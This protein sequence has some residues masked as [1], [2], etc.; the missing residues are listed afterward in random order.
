MAM[1]S[2]LFALMQ[3][4]RSLLFLRQLWRRNKEKK[5]CEGI[6]DSSSWSSSDAWSKSELSKLKENCRGQHRA[7]RYVKLKLTSGLLA[8]HG[9]SRRWAGFRARLRP[10]K[11]NHVC[12][13]EGVRIW[14]GSVVRVSRFDP[15]CNTRLTF[16]LT[17]RAT[18]KPT[19]RSNAK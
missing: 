10:H 7:F 12:D 13:R 17:T 15:S 5:S 6:C 4:K 3:R 8:V 16:G 18:I 1:R 2:T 19:R 14:M 11:R 9:D